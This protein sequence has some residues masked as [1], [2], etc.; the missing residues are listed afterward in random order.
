MADRFKTGGYGTTLWHHR[1]ECGHVISQ[2]RKSPKDE[3]DCS[4]CDLMESLP[5][6]DPTGI[7]PIEE[8]MTFLEE[9]AV[10]DQAATSLDQESRAI[11]L[12]AAR[13][14]VDPTAVRVFFEEGRAQGGLVYLDADL[15]SRIINKI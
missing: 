8:I 7:D 15:V 14:E 10:F 13:F 9:P 6:E 2:Q 5:E 4:D 11:V 3:L 12:I 1:L